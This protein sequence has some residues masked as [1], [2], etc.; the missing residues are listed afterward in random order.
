[1]DYNFA[2]EDDEEAGKWLTMVDS[3]SG[4]VWLR[5]VESRGMDEQM[6][7]IIM[8]MS[9]ELDSWGYR[10]EKLILRSDQEPA[11]ESVKKKLAEYREGETML[12]ATP[13]GESGANGRVEEA[14]QKSA[15]RG[16]GVQGPVGMEDRGEVGHGM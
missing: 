9:D 8:E 16:E 3:K 10:G 13:V 1:M 11:I 12:E 4:A 6:E 15:G 7:W 14:G 5:I 2:G